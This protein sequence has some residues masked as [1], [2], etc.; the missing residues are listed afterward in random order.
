[1]ANDKAT[2]SP[3]M[4]QCPVCF[5]D[6]KAAAINGHLDACLQGSVADSSQCVKYPELEPPLK[7]PR[8]TTE[9][10]DVFSTVNKTE[11]GCSSKAAVF[12]LF[13]THKC[14]VPVPS[15]K[16]GV[17]S[18]KQA[19]ANKGL[20]RNLPNDEPGTAGAQISEPNVDTSKASQSMSQRSLLTLNKPL[21]ETLRPNTLEEYFGQNKVIGQQTLFRSLLESQEIPSLVLWGPPGCGK[22]GEGLECSISMSLS[23]FI[24]LQLIWKRCIIIHLLTYGFQTLSTDS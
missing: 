6:F 14:K 9:P 11:A 2:T 3:G 19:G 21:A 17:L 22:V 12:S 23:R 10:D 7:K 1:M 24:C 16:S 20:K 8:V 18:T 13:Q 4:V 5:N 15:D